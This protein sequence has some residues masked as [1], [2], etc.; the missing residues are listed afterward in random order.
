MEA[1]TTSNGFH[2]K[3][4]NFFLIMFGG[5]DELEENLQIFGF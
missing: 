2:P 5:Q 3:Q 4:R 1:K